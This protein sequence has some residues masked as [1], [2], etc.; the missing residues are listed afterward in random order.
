MDE[1]IETFEVTQATIDPT[2]KASSEATNALN[3]SV[4]AT[5]EQTSDT[6]I[7]PLND[8]FAQIEFYMVSGFYS[9]K[10]QQDGL[11]FI[12]TFALDKNS[13]VRIA[14]NELEQEVFAYNYRSDDFTYIYYFD[15]ELMSKT[16][17]NVDTGAILQDP[18]GY[19]ESL[20][21][22]AE[23]IKI[24][25]YALLDTAGLTVEDL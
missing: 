11:E 15:G 18:D 13:F 21:I 19:T 17:F 22:D 12:E 3:E 7:I 10:V 2:E 14:E 1:A 24:Y 6:Q 16:I 9:R 20:K 8:K 4:Q 25:F 5:G 23:E